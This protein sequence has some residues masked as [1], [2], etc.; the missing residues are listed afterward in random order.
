MSENAFVERYLLLGLRLGGLIPGLVDAFYG[1]AALSARVEVEGTPDP[2]AL[3]A[4]AQ[5]LLTGLDGSVEGEQRTRWLR[6]QLVGLET[7]A[8]RLAGE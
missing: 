6:A 3:A 5:G 1:P 4:E 2:A 8:R 7:V